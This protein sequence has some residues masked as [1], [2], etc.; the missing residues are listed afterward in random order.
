VQSYE[1]AL[2][3]FDAIVGR[4][5]DGGLGANELLEK[6]GLLDKMGRYE[7]RLPPLP[8]ATASATK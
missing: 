1:N 4:N 8:K 5:Q 2:A 7:R 3:L 6:G